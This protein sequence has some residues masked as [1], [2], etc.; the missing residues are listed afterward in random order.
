M[1]RLGIRVALYRVLGGVMVALAF[2]GAFLPML[3]TTPFLLVAVW[4]FARSSPE[5]A[6]RLRRHPRF[7][8]YIVR[9][10]EK[11]AIPPSGKAAS[12]F[13]MSISYA[14]MLAA[15]RGLWVN[16]GVGAVLLCVAAYVLSRPSR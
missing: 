2:A 3:P 4:A 5:L 8:P 11:R 9:W 7:G 15:H 1:Q 16:V 6:E 12:I 14:L 13:G 10:E